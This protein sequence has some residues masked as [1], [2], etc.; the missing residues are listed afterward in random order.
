VKMT[1]TGDAAIISL[2]STSGSFKKSA[3]LVQ[4]ALVTDAAV[5][6]LLDTQNPDG[7]WGAGKGKQ[8]NTEATSIATLALSTVGD[9][10]LEEKIGRGLNWLT[11]RQNSNGSW[12][13]TASSKEPSWTTALAI[14][15]LTHFAAHRQKALR[16]AE[17]LLRQEGKFNFLASLLYRFAPQTMQVKLNPLLKGWPWTTGTF[18]WVEPTAYALIALK[19]IR[20]YLTDRRAQERIRQG[21]LM[22]YDRMCAE[23]GWN[24]GNSEVLE[25]DLWP[26]PD[27]TALALIALQDRRE[28]QANQLSLK[29]LKRMLA[30]NHS[31]LTLSWSVICFSLYGDDPTPLR[32]SLAKNYEKGAFLGETKTV[33][34]ALLAAGRGI[35][36]F[37][38]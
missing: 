21:E 29:S 8:S 37:R 17:W 24:Y 30:E 4:S 34:L 15:A 36:L 6:F 26:Y 35:E 12:P 20:P 11:A 19:K 2:L 1:E 33:A 31:G 7:G 13:L 23:G 22:I 5:Q 14:L 18:S 25:A 3:N 10:A 9:A 38:V 16:G 32:K 27:I 28:T